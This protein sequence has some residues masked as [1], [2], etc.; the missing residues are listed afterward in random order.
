MRV[1]LSSHAAMFRRGLQH[2][3]GV[4]LL[5]L[6]ALACE[7]SAT[8]F[9]TEPPPGDGAV[10]WSA[11]SSGVSGAPV[12]DAST[13]YFATVD[14]HLIATDRKT[15]AIRWTATTDARA[16]ATEFG[17]NVVLAGSIVSFGDYVVYGFDAA[18]GARRWVFDPEAQGVAGY[19][20]GAYELRTD[21]TT[22]Y[23]GSG[24]GH[25]Y[26]INARDGTL[27]WVNALAPG[28]NTSVYDPVI[29]GSA[30]YV[31]V[32]HF[33]NPITG[34]LDALDR[35]TGKLL[36]SRN[37][38]PPTTAGTGSGPLDAVVLYNGLVIVAI[39]DGTIH[40]VDRATGSDVWVAPR[41]PNVMALDD[42][43]PLRVSGSILIAGS[44]VPVLVGYDAETGRLLWQV[45]AGQGSDTKPFA[46]DDQSV[47]VPFNNGTLGSFDPKTG[48]E[49]WLRAAPHGA[50]FMS[51]PFIG[52]DAVFAPT[53]QGLVALTK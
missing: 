8:R 52:A 33:T 24:S 13:V 29:D 4:V 46:A 19:A 23:A 21:G 17:Q 39:D 31:T 10:L 25:A 14:H 38:G 53:T 47:Y 28:G 27:V 5:P 18:T 32:R 44:S 6:A 22:I 37:F 40:A 34:E 49:R 7:G 20:A 48:A 45:D 15:G 16:A 35:S 26:A 43:R 42:A 12:A 11:G 36:W 1:F 2:R 30:V 9:G 41:L 51:Y 50:Y 3:F